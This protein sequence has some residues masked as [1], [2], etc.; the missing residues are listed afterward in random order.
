MAMMKA[1]KGYNTKTSSAAICKTSLTAVIDDAHQTDC[2]K[3]YW[4]QCTA[5]AAGKKGGS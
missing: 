3:I 5:E 1:A 2:S 4:W